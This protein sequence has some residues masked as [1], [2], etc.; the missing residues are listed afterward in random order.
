LSARRKRRLHLAA[1]EALERSSD[2][3]RVKRAAELA[4]H[5]LQ[6]DDPERALPYV[7]QAGDQSTAVFAY[8]AAEDYYRTALELAREVADEKRQAEALEKQGAAFRKLT[9][10]GEALDSLERAA[11]MYRSTGDREGVARS[12]A[13]LAWTHWNRGTLMEG[14]TQSRAFLEMLEGH[15]G[16]SSGAH[17]LASAGLASLLVA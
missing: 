2:E 4:W 17:G 12:A 3:E 16:S 14:I 13:Q 1:A 5:F 7:I 11:A 9:R 6:G 10:Y 15:A 8:R